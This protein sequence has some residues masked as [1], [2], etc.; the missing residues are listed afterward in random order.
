MRSRFSREWK[1]S[2]K[3]SKQRAYQRNAPLHIRHRMMAAH[4]SKELNRKYKRRSIAVRKGDQ[5]KVMR[6]QFKGKVG[7][8]NRADLKKQRVYIDGVEVNKKD[9]S[10]AFY[11][12]HP[13]KLLIIDLN[14][15]DKKRMAAVNRG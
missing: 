13:S 1:R 15:E 5:V 4:L 14:T 2:R 11:P 3:P 10:K 7:R 6:G 12:L 8:I 9:G